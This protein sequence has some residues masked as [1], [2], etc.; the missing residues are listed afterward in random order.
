MFSLMINKGES[1][2]ASF[3]K[4]SFN[5]TSIIL[6][7]KDTIKSVSMLS[8]IILFGTSVE[9]SVHSYWLKESIVPSF[10]SLSFPLNSFSQDVWTICRCLYKKAMGE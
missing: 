7:F 10:M 2:K 6:A 9:L 5:Q 4:T 1:V 8:I 3:I